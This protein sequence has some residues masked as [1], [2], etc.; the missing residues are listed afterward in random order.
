MSVVT[1]PITEGVLTFN[2]NAQHPQSTKY[3]E[4]SF[5][6][7]QFN[8]AFGGT[9]AADI[10]FIENK[11]CWIIEIKDYRQERRTKAIDLADEIALKARDTII[12]LMSAAHKANDFDE[13]QFAKN[14]ISCEKIK[15][16]L[17]LEQ[18][19]NKTRL[20]PDVIDL[21]SLKQKLKK[22]LKCLGSSY[23]VNKETLNSKMNW[24]VTSYQAGTKA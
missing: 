16:V 10:V 13:K 3:D 22:L 20:R 9:K 15:I 11:T 12:G 6:R 17:H 18:P 23:V 24:T 7:N 8:S 5:Y 21:S 1:S 19:K 4:W 14:A 2:F